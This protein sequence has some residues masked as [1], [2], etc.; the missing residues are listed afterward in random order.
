MATNCTGINIKDYPQI[1]TIQEGDFL[2]VETPEGTAIIDY[3][4]VKINLDQTTFQPVISGLVATTTQLSSDFATLSSNIYDSLVDRINNSVVVF[5][6]MTTLSSV[7]TFEGSHIKL[8]TNFIEVNNI[9]YQQTISG[10]DT[11]CGIIVNAAGDE[12]VLEA[13]TYKIRVDARVT[14]LC[15][16]PSWMQIYLYQDD[17][18]TQVL[19]HGSSVAMTGV[20]QVNNLFLD[21][22]FYLCRTT[23]ITV[24]AH[25]CGLFNL[26][27]PSSLLIA[28]ATG[29]DYATS[30][31]NFNSSNMDVFIQKVS[32]TTRP[33]ILNKLPTL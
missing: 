24:R 33:P 25:T 16:T 29:D 32:N 3:G 22:Y 21:G 12:F 7:Q 2:I 10:T 26:G 5:K 13:G 1:N 31:L 15:S 4:D 18:P 17:A 8:P 30:T 23:T 11:G 14:S 9:N 19:Q 20:N 6:N 27:L 28:T